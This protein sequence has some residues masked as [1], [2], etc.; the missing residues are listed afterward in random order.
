MLSEAERAAHWEWCR[1]FIDRQA[2]W[3][4]T[5]EQPGIPGKAKGSTYTW[6]FYLRRATFNPKFAARLGAL[7]WEHFLASHQ[8]Q[9]FQICACHPSGPPIAMAIVAAAQPLGISVNAFLA[10]REPK[11]FGFDNWFDG[12]VE[13]GLPV[14]LV[15][16]LAASAPFL[17]RAAARVQFKLGLPLHRSYFTIVNKVGRGF[18]KQAQ[19]TENLLDNQLISLFNM[20]NFART[21]EDFKQRYGEAPKWEGVV[22]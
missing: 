16:D 21:V 2:I 9:P 22:R 11:S 12:R 3:R 19:H 15:D 4:A 17:L 5:P 13:L 18:S 7:F 1:E 8:R 10:R 14:L 20:N 6:Q